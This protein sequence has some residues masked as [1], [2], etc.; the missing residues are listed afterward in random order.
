MSQNETCREIT[1]FL[2][3]YCENRLAQSAQR[4]FEAH[5]AQCPDCLRFLASYRTTRELGRQAL[6]GATRASP[7]PESTPTPPERLI[8]AILRA[9]TAPGSDSPPGQGLPRPPPRG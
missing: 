9:K 7:D 6:S 2:D 3:E 8:Q 4:A 5:I 1:A